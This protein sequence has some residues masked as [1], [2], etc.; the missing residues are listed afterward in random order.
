MPHVN[1]RRMD[2]HAFVE[3]SDELRIHCVAMGQGRPL[4]FI[5]GWTMDAG[6]FRENLGPLLEHFRVIA[7]DPLSQRPV[8]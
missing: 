8:S 2:M 7:Y 1:L 4:V 6:C 5:P 3:T